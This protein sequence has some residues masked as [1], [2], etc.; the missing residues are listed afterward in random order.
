MAIAHLNNDF[1]ASIIIFNYRYTLTEVLAF[2]ILC[3]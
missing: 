2:E 3:H 1:S